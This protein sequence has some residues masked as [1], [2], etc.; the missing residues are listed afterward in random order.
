MKNKNMDYNS[1]NFRNKDIDR[2]SSKFGKETDP[3]V[4]YEKQKNLGT[5]TKSSVKSGT[6]SIANAVNAAIDNRLANMSESE[7]SKVANKAA[8][9]VA[10]KVFT[11]QGGKENPN[12]WKFQDYSSYALGV[13]G[14]TEEMESAAKKTYTDIMN[15]GKKK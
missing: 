15:R 14:H 12:L 11:N 10:E 8:Q 3:P 4:G 7:K 2:F 1:I 9:K 5:E 6:N 13:P